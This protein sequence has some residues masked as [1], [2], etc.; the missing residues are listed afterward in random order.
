[1]FE[2][3]PTLLLKVHIAKA[4]DLALRPELVFIITVI[5]IYI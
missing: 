1:M 4:V 2:I 5:S 3:R